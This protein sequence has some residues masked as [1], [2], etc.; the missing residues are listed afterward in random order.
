MRQGSALYFLEAYGSGLNI[1]F[2]LLFMD[3]EKT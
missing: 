3:A 1:C 2:E